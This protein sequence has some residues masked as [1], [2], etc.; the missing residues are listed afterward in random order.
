LTSQKGLKIKINKPERF[1][2]QPKELLIDIV[3]TYGNMMDY[4]VFRRHV[5]N[6]DRSYSDEGF[7]GAV[8]ILNS[9]KK[10]I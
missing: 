8:K 10:G 1:Y 9:V 2:F 5:I 7:E 3:T 4:E 6:D